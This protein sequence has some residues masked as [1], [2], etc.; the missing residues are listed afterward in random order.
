MFN[1]FR[2]NATFGHL[3]NFHKRL[4]PLWES[5]H[6]I[7]YVYN[8]FRFHYLKSVCLWG[9]PSRWS[10]KTKLRTKK[11]NSVDILAGDCKNFNAFK[12]PT[13]CRF[14]CDRSV[15]LKSSIGDSLKYKSLYLSRHYSPD[16]ELHDRFFV[17]FDKTLYCPRGDRCTYHTNK[18]VSCFGPMIL[19][20]QM[21]REITKS[22]HDLKGRYSCQRWENVQCNG[23]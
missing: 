13:P 11:S 23:T 1:P 7:R 21:K 5:G 9:K 19:E 2:C 8:V 20:C 16:W 10:K 15:A 14:D 6:L 18:N 4:L 22:T 3:N 12:K 17:L